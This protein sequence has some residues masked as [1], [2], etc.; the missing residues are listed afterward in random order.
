M[1]SQGARD[2]IV[3]RHKTVLAAALTELDAM[4]MGRPLRRKEEIFREVRMWVEKAPAYM[5]CS[6]E[7]R[8]DVMPREHA[9]L[10]STCPW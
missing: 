8:C 1:S 2:K 4:K 6:A 7:D 3:F 9:C 10:E 5:H